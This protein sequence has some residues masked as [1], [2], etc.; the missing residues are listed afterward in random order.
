MHLRWGREK[1]EREEKEDNRLKQMPCWVEYHE[2]S[3]VTLSDL[4]HIQEI[5]QNH[6]KL[7]VIGFLLKT[8]KMA[9]FCIMVFVVNKIET[10]RSGVGA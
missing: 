6:K 10:V 5:L 7:E 8:N 2:Q 9:K 3:K 1:K 4:M